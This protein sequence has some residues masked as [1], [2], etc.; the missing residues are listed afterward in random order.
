MVRKERPLAI[1][2]SRLK[3]TCFQ[4][5]WIAEQKIKIPDSLYRYWSLEIF[6]FHQIQYMLEAD[7]KRRKLGRSVLHDRPRPLKEKPL[8]S[9]CCNISSS[10]IFSLVAVISDSASMPIV[11][12]IL[13]ILPADHTNGHTESIHFIDL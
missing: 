8:Q 7:C 12:E 4:H 5:Y 1:D 10:S 3:I 9:S 2:T 13:M 6:F 11:R